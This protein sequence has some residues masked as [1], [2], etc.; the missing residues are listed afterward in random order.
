[1][2]FQF[3]REVHL[4]VLSANAPAHQRPQFKLWECPNMEDVRSLGT[5]S[6]WCG[7]EE[8]EEGGLAALGSTNVVAP[9]LS[10]L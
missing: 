3:A 7:H 2:Q 10:F 6:P 5:G 4:V 9:R 8:R 1:M